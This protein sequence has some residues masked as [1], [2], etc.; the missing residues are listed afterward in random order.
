MTLAVLFDVD[1]T[2]VDHVTASR[3]AVA[4]WARTLAGGF[5]YDDA[6][7]CQ[8]WLRLKEEHFGRY[9]GG[10]VTFEE[11]RRSRLADFMAYLGQSVPPRADLDLL[12]AA[13][14]S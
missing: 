6:A 5:D 1:G 4:R 14:L 13:Y 9:L 7:L 2:L 11:Q 8:Q 10:E 3:T 12:F